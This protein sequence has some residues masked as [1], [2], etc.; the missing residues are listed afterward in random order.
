MAAVSVFTGVNHFTQ[1]VL[2]Q[3]PSDFLTV[4]G[5]NINVE[6]RLYVRVIHHVVKQT[7]TNT[8]FCFPQNILQTWRAARNRIPVYTGT[9]TAAPSLVR[10]RGKVAESVVFLSAN[11]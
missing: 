10:S 6:P 11:Q 7:N 9:S 1:T 5:A 2:E 3:K 4:M 8:A